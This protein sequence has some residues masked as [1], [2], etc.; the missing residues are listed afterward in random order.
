MWEILESFILANFVVSSTYALN[1]T[2]VARNSLL[3]AVGKTAVFG[4]VGIFIVAV[5]I[6]VNKKKCIKWVMDYILWKRWRF[7]NP[8]AM[9]T[10]RKRQKVYMIL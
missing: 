3:G 6:F 5:H 10:Y 8:Q 7:T 4:L 9:I 1:Q 2:G